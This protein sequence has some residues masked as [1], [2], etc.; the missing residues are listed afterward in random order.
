M[1]K[2]SAKVARIVYMKFRN[3]KHRRQ[4]VQ[5]PCTDTKVV[6]Q[7]AHTYLDLV[8][9]ESKVDDLPVA[10][11]VVAIDEHKPLAEQS[12]V[13]V[14][15]VLGVEPVRDEE[16]LLDDVQVGNAQGRPRP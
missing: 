5:L 3:T 10:L 13:G 2:A 4:Y 6:R 8:H 7:D 9:V 15:G 14:P 12:N 1:H 16:H 11:P